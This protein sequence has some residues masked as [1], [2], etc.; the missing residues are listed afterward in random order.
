MWARRTHGG[1]RLLALKR[2]R[3][4]LRNSPPYL[5]LIGN[6]SF[7]TTCLLR[8][9]T[10]TCVISLVAWVAFCLFALLREKATCMRRSI[11]ALALWRLP[12]MTIATLVGVT[13][14]TANIAQKGN[15]GNGT[16]GDPPDPVQQTGTTGVSPVEDITNTLHFSAIAVSSNGTVTLTAAWPTNF[17]TADQTLDVLHKE[18]LCD[19]RFAGRVL[20]RWRLALGIT[21]RVGRWCVSR[22]PVIFP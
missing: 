15:R 1:H 20:V 17:L 12:R 7:E 9:L 2:R 16:T 6:N 22:I 19:E 4:P 21:G 14:V 8:I 5:P 11:A 10:A 13:I 18:N 3:A